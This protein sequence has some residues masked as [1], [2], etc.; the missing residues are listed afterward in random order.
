MARRNRAELVGEWFNQHGPAL[1]LY[2]RQLVAAS[3]AEDIV[4]RVFV[5]LLSGRQ[6]ATIVATPPAPFGPFGGWRYEL[7]VAN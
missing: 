4:Q 7:T 2:A 6:S 5:S 3:D 1:M